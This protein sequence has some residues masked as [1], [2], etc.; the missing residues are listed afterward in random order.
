GSSDSPSAPVNL[1][2]REVKKDSVTLSWE[3]PLIDGGAKITNYI[4][5][6]RETTRKAY[7]TITNNCTK[8]TFRIENLQEGCSY[9]F[10]VLASNEYGIGL[11]AETTEPVKV[12]EPPL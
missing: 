3:P 2:I 8:T 12:S 7:A 5:E 10:R 1:T 11:P 6:K 4:V 9:Y